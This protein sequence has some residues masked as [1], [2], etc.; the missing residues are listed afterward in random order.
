MV[1][2]NRLSD[3]RKEHLVPIP[4]SKESVLR[5]GVLYGANGAG[6]SNLF[7]ALQY[8][9][10]IALRQQK[11]GGGTGRDSFRFGGEVD[12]TSCFDLQ[13]IVSERLY[14]FG[15]KVDDQR[16]TEE[17]LLQI[18]GGR[19][20][21]LYERIT[22]GNGKVSIDAQGLKDAGD[23]IKAL[24]MVGG[25][26]NQSFLSTINHTLDSRDI[27]GELGDI[28]FWFS[29]SLVLISPTQQYMRLGSALVDKPDL[30]EFAGEFLKF[31]STGVDHLKIQETEVSEEELRRILPEHLFTRVVGGDNDDRPTQMQLDVGN[32][33][34]IQRQGGNF[35]KVNIQAAHEHMVGNI[36]TL[37]LNQ[38]SDGTRR[39]LNLIPALHHLRA[40]KAV[41]FIDEIDRSLHP[42]LVRTFLESFMKSCS[43]GHSQII[44][45][46]HESNLLD[47]DLLRRDEI[48]FAEKD[49]RGSTRLYSL[50]DFKIRNDLEIRK[51]YLQGRF[52]AIPF[53]GDIDGLLSEKGK[54]E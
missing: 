14:R 34:V 1:A 44:V 7:K 45:T 33:V 8:I 37:E 38:E 30:L 3:S 19:D 53:F 5:A 4:D 41:Y 35:Y 48:W 12:H 49:Q 43:G 17:W 18:I 13:F 9:K 32:V 29:S 20:K 46:T 39:L 31:A 16:I 51:H 47:Q 36:V 2:S 23:K 27:E 6:K 50:M 42:I 21:V 28:L 10:L 54:C 22:D 26:E 40:N 11:K 24:A 15:F 25:L 52:G